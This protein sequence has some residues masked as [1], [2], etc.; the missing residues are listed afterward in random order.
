LLI[1]IGYHLKSKK[2]I[3]ISQKKQYMKYL[4]ASLLISLLISSN[5]PKPTDIY[6]IKVQDIIGNKVPMSRYK[7]KVLL[8]VNVASKCKYTYQYDDLQ[9]LFDEYQDDDFA[10]LAFPANNFKA[11]E[12]GSNEEINRFCTSEYGVTFPMFSKISVKGDEMHPLYKFLTNKEQNGRLDAPINWNFQKFL[13]DKKGRVIRSFLPAERVNDK[14]IK[15]AI[16]KQI[17]K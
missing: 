17:K 16:T 4:F 10:V 1:E 8:I 11:Q 5:A 3:P 15:N 12:P 9:A 14:K 13:I 6:D 7:G 2:T